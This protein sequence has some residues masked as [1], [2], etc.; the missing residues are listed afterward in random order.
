MILLCLGLFTVSV[1]LI[2]KYGIKKKETSEY[3]NGFRDDFDNDKI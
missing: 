3:V 2:A 1:F